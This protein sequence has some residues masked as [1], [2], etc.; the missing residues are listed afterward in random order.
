MHAWSVAV[1]VGADRPEVV[2]VRDGGPG[3]DRRHGDAEGARQIDD[4]FDGVPSGP[5]V[6][7]SFH[8]VAARPTPE[9]L[10]QPGVGPEVRPLD[11]HREVL[12]L[13]RAEHGEADPS[14]EGRLNGRDLDRTLVHGAHEVIA[15]AGERGVQR[16]ERVERDRDA[17]E[18]RDVDVVAPT[19]GPG[20]APGGQG[21]DGRPR[22][23]DPFPQ[24]PPGGHGWAFGGPPAA[25][26]SRCGLQ[27]ELGCRSAGPGPRLP[28]G[29]H[30]HDGQS[31]VDRLQVSP[32]QANGIERARPGRFYEKVGRAGEVTHLGGALRRAEV[33]DDTSLSSA[34]ERRERGMLSGRGRAS[35]HPASPQWVAVGGFQLQDLGS[36]VDQELGAVAAGQRGGEV[37]NK[38]AFE[39]TAH[40]PPKSRTYYDY[41]NREPKW[42]SWD[43]I[44]K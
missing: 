5:C 1:F 41:V 40:P 22:S 14:I 43:G 31:G 10:G 11:H 42:G 26:G 12:P 19:R 16:L 32:A 8:V 28:E 18:G 30:G 3:S 15:V 39:W 25:D 6:H 13:L 4:L 35:L 7:G 36:A 33:D 27:G 21:A 17:L 2:H 24:I 37:Q 34:E 23:G 44:G 29:R 38:Q 9:L 20:P